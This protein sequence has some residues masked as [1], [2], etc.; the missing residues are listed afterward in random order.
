MYLLIGLP[1]LL[2]VVGDT[3][4]VLPR[5]EDITKSVERHF[6]CGLV[7]HDGGVHIINTASLETCVMVYVV[8]RIMG[9][10][11]SHQVYGGQM[12]TVERV[13]GSHSFYGGLEA[14]L[15]E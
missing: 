2:G 14:C 15:I 8:M 4:P 13:P 11:K 1:P 5:G 6:V 3:L 7:P 9:S 10:H 12:M